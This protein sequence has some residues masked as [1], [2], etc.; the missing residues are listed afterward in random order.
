MKRDPSPVSGLC[1][2]GYN[3]DH[4]RGYPIVNVGRRLLRAVL[5]CAL[6]ASPVISAAGDGQRADRV[7]AAKSTI[8]L[9]EATEI[10][11]RAYGGRVLSASPASKNG[12]KG[13]QVRVLLDGGRVKTVFVDSNGSVR[14]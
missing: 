13:Y 4:G 6:L 7:L 8:S 2:K 14:G 12:K 9:E 5:L 1:A 10:V 3:S 11:R